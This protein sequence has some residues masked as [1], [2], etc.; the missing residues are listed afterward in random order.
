MQV[1]SQQLS[2]RKPKGP[3]DKKILKLLKAYK[4]H[5]CSHFRRCCLAHGHAQKLALRPSGA[6]GRL[7]EVCVLVSCVLVTSWG[8]HNSSD[9]VL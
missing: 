1:L 7:L 6:S 5:I 8:D 3:F 2:R 9:D 4:I